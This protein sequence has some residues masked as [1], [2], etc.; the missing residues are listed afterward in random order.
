[1]FGDV[2]DHFKHFEVPL[3]APEGFK[4]IEQHKKLCKICYHEKIDSIFMPCKHKLFC[5]ACKDFLETICPL[6]GGKIEDIVKLYKL[7]KFVKNVAQL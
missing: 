1:M 6:C 2:R 7:K 4:P 5:Y 3:L